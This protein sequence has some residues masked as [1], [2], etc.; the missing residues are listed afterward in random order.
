MNA[1]FTQVKKWA[2]SIGIK[3]KKYSNGYYWYDK[4]NTRHRAKNI[5]DLVDQINKEVSPVGTQQKIDA[6]IAAWQGFM[7]FEI[8]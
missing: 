7:S 4:S 1:N 5:S 6:M 8:D 2:N 3:I